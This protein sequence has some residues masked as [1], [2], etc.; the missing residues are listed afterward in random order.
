MFSAMSKE[1][2]SSLRARVEALLPG[3]ES[4]YPS[5]FDAAVDLGLLRARVC[6]PS[7][8]LLSNRH[9]KVQARAEHA[10][11]EQWGGQDGDQNPSAVTSGAGK[12]RSA[13]R[14]KRRG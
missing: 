14:R 12:R 3:W 7:S 9:A 2:G 5:V 11:R 8:L 4:W 10:H 1:D 13:R 6:A